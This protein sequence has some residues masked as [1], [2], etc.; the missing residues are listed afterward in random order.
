MENWEIKCTKPRG[1]FKDF[2]KNY[3]HKK[4][5]FIKVDS[6]YAEIYYNEQRVGHLENHTATFVIEVYYKRITVEKKN[7]KHVKRFIRD[8][9]AWHQYEQYSFESLERRGMK[10]KG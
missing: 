7:K 9:C 3:D 6:T 10:I 4:I 5:E 2:A 1:L 8:Y